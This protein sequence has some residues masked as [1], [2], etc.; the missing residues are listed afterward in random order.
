MEEYNL[1]PT[2]VG[3][4]LRMVHFRYNGKIIVINIQINLTQGPVSTVKFVD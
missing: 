1:I 2:G 4:G 3:A